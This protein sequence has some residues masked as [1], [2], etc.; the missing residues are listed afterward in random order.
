MYKTTTF[1]K[2]YIINLKSCEI[3]RLKKQ[4]E[5]NSVS[6]WLRYHRKLANISQQQLANAIGLNYNNLIK[7]I[8]NEYSYPSRD[9]SVKLS[10]YF[11]LHTK[12][13]YD[14]YLEETDQIHNLL[15][16]YRKSN[17][18]RIKDAAKLIKVS[19]KTWSSWENQKYEI[20]R[21]NY[22]KLKKLNIL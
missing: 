6:D 10:N 17:N 4:L 5:F 8:E 14:P 2:E 3:E 21:E 19:E 16:E 1:W 13:F 9:I 7:N 12:Y 15:L 18:L 11:N 22:Y 20:T